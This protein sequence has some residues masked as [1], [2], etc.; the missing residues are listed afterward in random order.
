MSRPHVDYDRIA[1]GYDRR[2]TGGGTPG[3]AAALSALAGE[4]GAEQILEVGCGTGH[5]LDGLRAVGRGLYGLDLSAGMLHQ[6][7]RRQ[8]ALHLVRGRAGRPP[9]AGGSLDLVYCVNAIHHF[10]DPRGFVHEGARL[11][12]PG[13]RLAV[14]GN[15]PRAEADRWYV[16]EYFAGTYETDLARFPSWDAVRDWMAGAG[17]TRLAWQPV[18]KIHDPKVGRAVLRDPFLEKDSASQLAMLSDEAYAAGLQRI[19][20]ALAAAEAVGETL[21]FAAD[22]TMGMLTGQRV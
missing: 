22:L 18:E 20:A 11:L 10:D 14:V 7:R 13:G 3:V 16:Y 2:F 12:R 6:A 9:F 5:W 15:D 17:F 21:T 8:A 1:P 19:E 4:L